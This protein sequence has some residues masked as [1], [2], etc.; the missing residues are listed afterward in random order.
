MK[1]FGIHEL[2]LYCIPRSLDPINIVTLLY[3]MGLDFL[4]RQYKVIQSKLRE[5]VYN[6]PR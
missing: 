6:I 5:C 4:D 3:K 2:A 1:I